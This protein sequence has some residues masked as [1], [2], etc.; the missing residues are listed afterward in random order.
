[1]RQLSTFFAIP[2]FL[3]FSCLL[4]LPPLCLLPSMPRYLKYSAPF[5]PLLL[6]PFLLEYSVVVKNV[7]C[8]AVRSSSTWCRLSAI[9]AWLLS[10]ASARRG[11]QSLHG[12]NE[13][14]SLNMACSSGSP[15]INRPVRELSIPILPNLL[16]LHPIPPLFCSHPCTTVSYHLPAPP[17]LLTSQDLCY[18]ET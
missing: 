8:A 12:K 17:L 4:P 16:C 3:F 9:E 6:L 13:L 11:N 14:L 5:P 1:M 7:S 18:D 2:I 10:A 15:Y